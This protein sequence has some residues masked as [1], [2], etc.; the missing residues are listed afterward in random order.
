RL[1]EPHFIHQLPATDQK[2]NPHKRCRVCY[3]KGS[4]FESRYYCP[5]C[6]GQPGLCIGRCFE[7]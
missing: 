7:H 6:P 2:A 4:R 1:N 5:K 3:K